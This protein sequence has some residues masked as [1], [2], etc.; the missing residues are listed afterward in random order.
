MI[1]RYVVDRG[2]HLEPAVW[3]KLPFGISV[4]FFSHY[5]NGFKPFPSAFQRCKILQIRGPF[6]FCKCMYLYRIEK[7]L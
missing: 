6:K 1:T 3:Y 5:E 7:S 4:S 2:L